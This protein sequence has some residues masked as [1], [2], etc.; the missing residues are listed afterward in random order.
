MKVLIRPFKRIYLRITESTSLKKGLG[1]I[2]GQILW[3]FFNCVWQS[4]TGKRNLW[5][6]LVKAWMII[7]KRCQNWYKIKVKV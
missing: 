7:S 3:R 5:K 1:S 4:L 6:K 2:S